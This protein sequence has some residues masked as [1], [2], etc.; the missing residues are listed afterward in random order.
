MSDHGRPLESPL[1]MSDDDIM[2]EIVDT[3]RAGR[4]TGTWDRARLREVAAEARARNLL[5]HDQY[6]E[7]STEN[8]Q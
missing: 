7:R 3:V 4:S 5:R 1:A 6:P 8:G 2:I